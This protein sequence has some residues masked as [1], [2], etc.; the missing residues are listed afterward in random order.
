[1]HYNCYC[2]V[3]LTVHTSTHNPI[4]VHVNLWYADL[5]NSTWQ[6]TCTHYN[7]DC[8]KAIHNSWFATVYGC[9]DT[10]D[11]NNWVC[12]RLGVAVSSMV[13]APCVVQLR[14][15]IVYPEKGRQTTLIVDLLSK[16]IW[17]FWSSNP[18]WCVPAIIGIILDEFVCHDVSDCTSTC[19]INCTFNAQCVDKLCLRFWPHSPFCT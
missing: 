9:G 1:M 17:I 2:I 11:E 18:V 14:R 10:R 16:L 4:T 13:S 8:V 5:H 3:A 6:H 15:F 7:C 19:T 12:E